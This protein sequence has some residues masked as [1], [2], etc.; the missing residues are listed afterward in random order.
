MSR[1]DVAC[2]PRDMSCSS[3]SFRHAAP[4]SNTLEERCRSYIHYHP[5]V[6]IALR[7]QNSTPH[8]AAE[9]C[10]HPYMPGWLKW[11]QAAASPSWR[12][13][14]PF[15]YT[16][17]HAVGRA[18]PIRWPRAAARPGCHTAPA[19]S[20][21]RS[22]PPPAR[23]AAQAVARCC[24]PAPPQRAT[25]FASSAA[26]EGIYTPDC[27]TETPPSSA[28][29]ACHVDLKTHK[30][31]IGPIGFINMFEKHVRRMSWLNRVWR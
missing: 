8:A 23:S 16:P 7:A 15:D 17:S 12:C 6:R 1:P 27:G 31:N 2:P 19:H 5:V 21:V 30:A 28:Y 26:L 22:L 9:E 20:P 25:T 10:A 24:A 11:S 13:C 18:P 14:A 4:A 29:L 3:F